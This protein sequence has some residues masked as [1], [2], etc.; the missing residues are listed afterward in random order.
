MGIWMPI[1][2]PSYRSRYFVRALPTSTKTAKLGLLKD[3]LPNIYVKNLSDSDM[4]FK[5]S[6]VLRTK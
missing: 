2:H 4:T 6:T 3:F 1:G 5:Q